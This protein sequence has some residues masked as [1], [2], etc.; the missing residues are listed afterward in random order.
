MFD[1]RSSSQSSVLSWDRTSFLKAFLSTVRNPFCCWLM[2][3]VSILTDDRLWSDKEIQ[4]QT[5][6]NVD[7]ECDARCEAEMAARSFCLFKANSNHETVSLVRV[8]MRLKVEIYACLTVRLKRSYG[9]ALRMNKD[10]NRSKSR[11]MRSRR[12]NFSVSTPV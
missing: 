5:M 7:L 1:E 12:W 6:P 11:T 8:G 3:V 9:E 2:S 4:Q 10:P